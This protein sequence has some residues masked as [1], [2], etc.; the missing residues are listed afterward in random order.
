MRPRRS[1]PSASRLAILLSALALIHCSDGERREGLTPSMA[2]TT[3]SAS[4]RPETWPGTVRLVGGKR[5]D[6]GVPEFR[7]GARLTIE[8]GARALPANTA[9]AVAWRRADGDLVHRQSEQG[10]L[11]QDVL[12]LVSPSTAAWQPGDYRAVVSVAGRDIHETQFRISSP[13]ATDSSGD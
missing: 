12:A 5:A 10:R 9:V 2:R 13:G 4:V 8:V 1:R 11:G 7:A 6:D 3:D